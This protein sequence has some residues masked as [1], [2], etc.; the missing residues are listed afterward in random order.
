VAK[1]DVHAITC[2]IADE[3]ERTFHWLLQRVF[4][5]L[6]REVHIAVIRNS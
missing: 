3:K 1:S 5:K 4:R 2:L 6:L